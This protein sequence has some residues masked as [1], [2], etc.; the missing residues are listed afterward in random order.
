MIATFAGARIALRIS[1]YMRCRRMI[2]WIRRL[3]LRRARDISVPLHVWLRLVQHLQTAI[4]R[5]SWDD[6][7][8]VLYYF[9]VNTVIPGR[10]LSA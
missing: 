10:H 1:K 4:P 8:T 7:N 3:P 9:D 2:P 6:L 5:P